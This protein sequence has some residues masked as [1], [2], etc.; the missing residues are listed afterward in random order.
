MTST[1]QSK[2]KDGMESSCTIQPPQWQLRLIPVI[3]KPVTPMTSTVS[4]LSPSSCHQNGT[5]HSSP[6]LEEDLAI[7]QKIEIDR[8]TLSFS[9]TTPNL[10]FCHQHGQENSSRIQMTWESN[11]KET[12]QTV[13]TITDIRMNQKFFLQNGTEDS[14]LTL[15]ISASKLKGTFLMPAITLRLVDSDFGRIR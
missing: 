15:T 5:A 6:I 7:E 3:S 12:S 1:S 4:T 8:T 10:K 2:S 13:N 11:L 14:K 9:H